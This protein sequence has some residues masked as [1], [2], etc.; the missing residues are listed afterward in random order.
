LERAAQLL[1]AWQ[2]EDQLP[3]EQALQYFCLMVLN[4]NETVYI[5]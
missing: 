4:L 5:D 3:A 1:A 2:R